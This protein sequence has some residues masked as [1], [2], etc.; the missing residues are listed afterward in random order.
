MSIEEVNEAVRL[1]SQLRSELTSVA[2]GLGKSASPSDD[3]ASRAISSAT[4]RSPLSKPVFTLSK[5]SR[6][7]R[8]LN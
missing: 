5:V 1:W 3:A 6:Q 4:T 8:P 7:R 2:E